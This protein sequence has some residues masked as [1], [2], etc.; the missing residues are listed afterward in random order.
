MNVSETYVLFMK[1]ISF[2]KYDLFMCTSKSQLA[3][4]VSTFDSNYQYRCPYLKHNKVKE[5]LITTLML[6]LN[7]HAAGANILLCNVTLSSFNIQFAIGCVRFYFIT[8]QISYHL[9]SNCLCSPT[10]IHYSFSGETNEVTVIEI[11]LSVVRAIKNNDTFFYLSHFKKNIIPRHTWSILF[12]CQIVII[13]ASVST[14]K[15]EK[16]A[17]QPY[18]KWR[19]ALAGTFM[20]YWKPTCVTKETPL[21]CKALRGFYQPVKSFMKWKEIP[22]KWI[23]MHWQKKF[24]NFMLKGVTS[25][26][27]EEIAS[28]R[29]SYGAASRNILMYYL[30]LFHTNCVLFLNEASGLLQQTNYFLKETFDWLFKPSKKKNFLIR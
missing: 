12:L 9:I 30:S 29:P 13:S 23:G 3:I 19:A 18:K 21:L 8:C 10:T 16:C 20:N 27:A 26:D 15:R 5:S 28:T 14:C 4:V 2:E 6:S 24:C 1:C 25:T 11:I 17:K 7:V 22:M